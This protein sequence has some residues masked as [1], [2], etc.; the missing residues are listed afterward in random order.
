M[1]RE[2]TEGA[3]NGGE[4]G[5]SAWRGAGFPV[6]KDEKVSVIQSAEAL[7]IK[8]QSASILPLEVLIKIKGA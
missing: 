5:A 4:G 6:L 2:K 8:A 3:L 7:L 1:K